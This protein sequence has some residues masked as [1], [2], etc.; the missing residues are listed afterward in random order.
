MEIVSYKRM[1]GRSVQ[2]RLMINLDSKNWEI[3]DEQIRLLSKEARIPCDESQSSVV[4]QGKG[5]HQ[6][7]PPTFFVTVLVN[8]MVIPVNLNVSLHMR[9]EL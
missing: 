6:N 8:A 2:I 3:M 9:D 1:G 5:H 7:S 4:C